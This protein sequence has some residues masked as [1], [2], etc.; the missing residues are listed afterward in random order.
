MTAPDDRQII[1]RSLRGERDAFDELVRRYERQAYNLAYR[2]TGNYDDA[3]DV[4]VEAFVRAFQGLHTFR[5]DAN[6]STW[7]HRIVVNTFLD[8]RKRARG[9][10]H[11]SLEEQLE[12]DGGDT[13]TRQIEDTSPGPQELVEQE[14]RERALQWAIDQLPPERRILIVLY[15]FENLSYEEIAQIL[16][17][18]VGTVKS[19][20]NRARLALRE[21]LEPSRELFGR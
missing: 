15:H 19:R 16:N 2:L 10:Q 3:S 1:E 6:F 14:E 17:L 7:L 11:L 4:V 8:L 13:L 5:G 20:L 9:R 12:L 21:I 18:P